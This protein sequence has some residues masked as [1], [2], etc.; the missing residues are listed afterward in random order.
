MRQAAVII[1]LL[2]L[3][4]ATG[5]GQSSYKGLTPGTSTKADVLRVLGKEVKQASQTLLE[6]TEPG[7]EGIPQ[8]FVQY[9]DTSAAAVVERIELVCDRG[10]ECWKAVFGDPLIADAKREG[11]EYADITVRENSGAFI[12]RV[13]FGPP[14]FLVSTWSIN[15]EKPQSRLG[16]YSP[17][18]FESAVPK[19]C[20]G[21]LLGEWET[22]R[23]R[24]ILTDIPD[25]YRNGDR[26]GPETKGTFTLNN[27]TVTGSGRYTLTGEW[28]DA[29]GSGTFEIKINMGH[30]YEPNLSD[31]RTFTGTWERKTGKGPKKGTWE[32]RCVEPN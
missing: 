2:L 22:N 29:T 11:R 16:V 10:G 31:R 26:N 6:Y 9:R 3:A 32:G 12:R 8:I 21:T 17:E 14:L 18:L 15:R 5:F 28:R 7:P 24:L 1:L 13:Y 19:R 27:G 4:C 25:A 20:T 30:P 23:G